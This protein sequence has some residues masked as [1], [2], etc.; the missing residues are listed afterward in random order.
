MRRSGGQAK[1]KEVT[2]GKSRVYIASLNLYVVEKIFKTFEDQA[3]KMLW[4]E[5]DNDGKEEDEITQEDAWVV[6]NT[7]FN[8]KGL[9]R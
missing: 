8:E 7:Y 2:R 3:V 9:V 5:E 4:G 1:Q 6:I